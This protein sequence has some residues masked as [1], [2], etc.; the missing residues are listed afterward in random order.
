ML[1]YDDALHV[2]LD[3]A[4]PLLDSL[5]LKG[6]FYVS[7]ATGVLHKRMHEWK[8]AAANGHEL[9][10]HT[11]FHPCDGSL[12]VRSFVQ[13]EYDLA[14]YSVKRM[15]DEITMTNALLHAMDG[16]TKRTFAY[17]CG[18]RKIGDSLYFRSV[19]KDFTGARG[20]GNGMITLKNVDRYN[21]DC[22]MVNGQI[23][24]EL[25]SHVQKAM[26]EKKLLVFLFHGVGG[27]HG[28]NVS[29][30]AHREL[31]LFLKKHEQ[32]IWIAPMIDVAKFIADNE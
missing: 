22:I 23:G 11:M 21:I 17:P 8:Q 20:V 25:I 16:K 15:V 18:D 14:T 19:E 26:E 2:H 12:P 24:D 1:T 32:D 27:E 28:L 30:A 31:L 10:N 3:H 13:P 4:W 9:G 6:T 29:L 5:N 7:G